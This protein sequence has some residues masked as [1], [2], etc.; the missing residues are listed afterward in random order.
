MLRHYGRWETGIP[1]LDVT[2]TVTYSVSTSDGAGNTGTSPTYYLELT[3]PPVVMNLTTSPDRPSSLDAIT[4]SAEVMDAVV[5]DD[6]PKEWEAGSSVNLTMDSGAGL[7]L[8]RTVTR[9]DRYFAS[10]DNGNIY[11][12]EIGPDMTVTSSTVIAS[13][14]YRQRGLVSGDFDEDGDVDLVVMNRTSGYL[15]F[16]EQT[17]NWTFAA[18]V[19]TGTYTGVT[20]KETY[21]FAVGDFNEDGHLDI[22]GGG[23]QT[24]IRLF[25]GHGNGTFD[26]STLGTISANLVSISTGDMDNDGHLDMLVAPYSGNLVSFLG[27]GNGTFTSKTSVYPNPGAGGST[28]ATCLADFDGDGNLDILVSTGDLYLHLG[29]GDGVNFTYGGR[30]GDIAVGGEFDLDL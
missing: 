16:I 14:P 1:A 29:H 13:M 22:V 20:S 21:G 27:H 3:E 9:T 26:V 25:A 18:P 7:R 2:G 30:I 12:L 24:T 23:Y 19:S 5:R 15:Y 4:V 17:A 28:R 8:T 6:V 10:S 11:M